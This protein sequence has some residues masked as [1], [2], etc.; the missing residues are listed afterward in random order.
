MEGRLTVSE[1]LRD[2]VKYWS[3][4]V[5]KCLTK[6]LDADSFRDYVRLVQA[7]HRL[8]PEIIA[9]FFMRPLK[10]NC[11]SPD[12]RIPPYVSV[13]TK[14]R[15]TDAVSILRAL[16]RYSSLHALVPDQAQQDGDEAN[17][18]GAAKQDGQQ[19]STIRWKSSS[20]LEEVMFYH[21]IK[22]LVEGTAFRDSRTALELIHISSKWMSLFTAASNSMTADMLGG[23]LQDPQV[24]H[25]METAWGALVPLV[26]R[27]VDNAAFVKV[28]SQPSTKGMIPPRITSL[29][30]RDNS[31]ILIIMSIFAM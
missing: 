8:P 30:S 9:D 27:L 4:F 31:H 20:W 6:R 1:A 21:V 26:L 12:P 3:S 11:V 5:S 10:S 13:L 14:L 16:Y 7:K 28:I 29:L 25:E 22:L 19:E 2:S 17:G 18:E 24:R 15:Y 23:G